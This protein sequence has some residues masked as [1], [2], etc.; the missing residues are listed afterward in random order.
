M[1]LF[2]VDKNIMII[3]NMQFIGPLYLPSSNTYMHEK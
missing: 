1:F 3:Q 2:L